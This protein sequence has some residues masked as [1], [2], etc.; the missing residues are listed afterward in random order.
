MNWEMLRAE[1]RRRAR[2]RLADTEPSAPL[3]IRK[4]ALAFPEAI[5]GYRY[6]IE[7]SEDRACVGVLEGD[8]LICNSDELH[9]CHVCLADGCEYHMAHDFE[10]H[11]VLRIWKNDHGIGYICEVSETLPRWGRAWELHHREI[12]FGRVVFGGFGAGPLTITRQG[13]PAVPLRLAR[14]DTFSDFLIV[15]K[16]VVTLQFLYRP[17]PP[18]KDLVIPREAAVLLAPEELEFYFAV[19]LVF[20]TVY[21]GLDFC[22]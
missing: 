2:A 14:R 19:S 17:P 10:A 15:L 3:D 20:R 18:N 4:L 16:R 7:N 12:L 13:K 8:S 9:C 5:D 21:F 22:I 1:V 11:D 6:T